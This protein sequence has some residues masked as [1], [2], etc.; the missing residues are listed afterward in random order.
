LQTLQIRRVDIR[1][2]EDK[3]VEKAA[4]QIEKDI[5]KTAE[6]RRKDIRKT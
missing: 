5:G 4:E 6:R 1:C 2:Q 3:D